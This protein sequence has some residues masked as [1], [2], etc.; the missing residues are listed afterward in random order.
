M[1]NPRQ[2]IPD[3]TGG[4]SADPPV[5]EVLDWGKFK[6]EAQKKAVAVTH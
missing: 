5:C 6:C 1:A 3:G 2:V 4:Y